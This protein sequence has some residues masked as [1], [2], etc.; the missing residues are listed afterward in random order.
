MCQRTLGTNPTAAHDRRVSGSV[1]RVSL[2]AAI[3]A[4]CVLL[5]A[6]GSD[7]GPRG[8]ASATDSAGPPVCAWSVRADKATLNIAY[9]DTGATYWT[10]S[11]ALAPGE[12]LELS[13]R[14]PAARYFS[15]VS[16]GPIGGAVDVLSDR[17]IEPD[18]SST[19][20]FASTG[21]STGG[22]YTVT[23]E[24]GLPATDDHNRVAAEPAADTAPV[25]SGPPTTAPRIVLG[26]G[27]ADAVRGTVIYR[28]YLPT[29]RTDPMGGAGLPDVRLVNASGATTDIATC[30][31]P[32]PS[33][34]ALDIV[35]NYDRPVQPVPPTPVFI[36]PSQTSVNLYPN[37]DSVYVAT[38][39]TYQPGR[40]VVVRGRAPTFPNTR[41]G[42]VVTGAEEV[43]YWSMC[44]NELRK[45]YP[46]TA[47]AA[48]D[49][50]ALDSNGFYTYVISTP[51][52]RPA[53]TSATAGS[54]WL[55]WGST[56]VPMVLL[57]RHMVAN[58]S[59]AE[60]ATN[61]APGEV[62]TGVMKD[63]APRGVYCDKTTFE[64][65]GFAACGL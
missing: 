49:E 58:P 29:D 34:A 62:A 44:T 30:S 20:P 24:R 28:V 64:Q 32:G 36:R 15:F 55:D 45:P 11:Y 2:G 18:A 57:L 46:V 3:I 48:D 7:T 12:H 10:L 22:R 65:G 35:N 42:A 47:C 5:A 56:D 59:F 38:T 31:N 19:N 63:F 33:Q 8:A 51:A 21:G 41:S 60:A 9:P 43:R 25:S 50:T 13:G 4:V 26:S 1:D 53:A 23:V 54:S 17:D 39:A 37:P 40:V 6:C 16:Y 27:G 52:D 14:Y 61:V